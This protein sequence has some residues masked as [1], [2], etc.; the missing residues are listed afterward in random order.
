M[1]SFKL[2]AAV[3]E[4]V[5]V[6]YLTSCMTEV[7]DDDNTAREELSE[8]LAYP[9]LYVGKETILEGVV[10]SVEIRSASK[11][12]TILIIKLSPIDDN[13]SK[14]NNSSY[15]GERF[16]FLAKLQKV[17]EIFN[18]ISS[19]DSTLHSSSNSDLRDVGYEF[20]IASEELEALGYF[21]K[22]NKKTE[23]SQA[24]AKIAEAYST[25]A[26]SY[27]IFSDVAIK[28]PVKN[29]IAPANL[30][31]K[32]YTG[33]QLLNDA[34]DSII[35]SKYILL[36][37]LHTFD[38]EKVFIP[39]TSYKIQAHS[40]TLSA[41][42]WSEIKVGNDYQHKALKRLAK[43][44]RELGRANM[45]INEGIADLGKAL[46]KTAVR[47]THSK[48]PALRCAYFGY[49]GSHLV[50]CAQLLNSLNGSMNRTPVKIRGKLVRSDLREEVNVV[51]FQA[52]GFEVDGLSLSFNY[53]DENGAMK[54]T[55]ELYEWVEDVQ[56][57]AE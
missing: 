4:I 51:W 1:R 35:K 24:V 2:S 39:E 19:V 5:F 42:S 22:Q 13:K 50:R 34:A 9:Q 52:E 57:G 40:S 3:L 15:N 55:V 10:E 44:F 45:L 20:K 16:L 37:G 18:K 41:Q 30:E 7:Q 43:A 38:Y 54:S 26:E 14:K 29:E 49:N 33:A 23:T 6:L 46:S 17:N 12:V 8:L 36:K 11:G 56:K 32:L 48:D 28:S 25:A 47:W 31:N 21:L 53:G 27:F